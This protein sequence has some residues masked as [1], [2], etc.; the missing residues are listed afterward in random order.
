MN[1][2]YAPESEDDERRG[3]PQICIDLAQKVMEE[4]R[5]E[6]HPPLPASRA[7]SSM[8]YGRLGAVR[9]YRIARRTVAQAISNI[10][11][12]MIQRMR[13]SLVMDG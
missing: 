2:D 1:N 13:A 8:I 4:Y 5:I 12:K 11:G 10:I 9:R 7:P 3:D 6:R